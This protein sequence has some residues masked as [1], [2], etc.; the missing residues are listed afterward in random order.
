MVIKKERVEYVKK[1]WNPKVELLH[2]FIHNSQEHT[3]SLILKL[4]GEKL[5]HTEGN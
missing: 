4:T 5:S 2:L 3:V 1:L